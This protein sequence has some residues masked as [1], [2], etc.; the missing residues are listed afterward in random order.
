M[1]P[2]KLCCSAVRLNRLLS[3]TAAS[4][5]RLTSKTMRVPWLGLGLGLGL[6]GR[7]GSGSGYDARAPCSHRRVLPRL[8]AWQ[9]LQAKHVHGVG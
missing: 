4:A 6:G 2:A 9:W 7:L 3:T 5:S 1:L 8:Q